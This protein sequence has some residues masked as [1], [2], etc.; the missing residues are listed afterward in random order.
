MGRGKNSKKKK[1]AAAAPDM[2]KNSAKKKPVNGDEGGPV[3][4]EATAS[5]DGITLPVPTPVEPASGDEQPPADGD[6]TIPPAQTSVQPSNGDG[7]SLEA[8]NA[9]ELPVGSAAAAAS[10]DGAP[11]APPTAEAASNGGEMPLGSA[12]AAPDEDGVLPPPPFSVEAPNGDKTPADSAAED[13]GDV[14]SPT[15]GSAAVASGDVLE[16]P[17]SVEEA[18]NGGEPMEER[19]LDEEAPKERRDPSGAEPEGEAENLKALN[20]V[21]VKEAVETRGQVA[22]LTAQVDQ[23]SAD[24]DALA[25]VERDVLKAG[26]IVPFVAAAE[27]CTALRGHVA[28]VQESL[29][30]A[31]ARAAREAD[32]R[33]E[34]AARLKAAEAENLR[35]VELLSGKDAEVASASKNVAG[36]EA[37]VSELA[38]N[39]TKLCSEKCELEKQLG[40]MS[41]SARSVHAQKAEVEA[42]FRDYKMNTEKYKQEIQEKLDEKSRQLEALRSSKAEMEVKLQSLEAD[43]SAALAKNWELESEMHSSKT[44]L[45]AAKTELEKLRFEV[46]DVGKKY[47]AVLAEGDN[48]RNEIE[49]MIVINEG[50]VSAFATEKTK[51]DKEL[52][53]LKRKVDSIRAN[54]DVAMS[55]AHQK[56]AEAAKLRAEMNGLCDSIAEQRVL[57][58]DLRAKSSG[59][60]VEVDTVQKALDLEKAEGGKLRLK[61]GKLES[62]NDEKEHEIGVLKSEV[63]NKRGQIYTLNGELKKLQLAVDVAKQSGKSSVWTWLCP[64]TTVIAAVSFAYAARSR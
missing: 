33:E 4:S 37:V 61:L 10:L 11:P 28:D 36:L 34:A 50:A 31:K 1:A 48:L 46:A 15:V 9:D 24:A 60:Q 7:P 38:G 52:D 12:A 5:G 40:E 6:G 58:D 44:E 30:A 35:F 26:L 51:M 62:Y 13:T 54:K 22:A 2:A 64:T 43:L 32:A 3:D 55:S 19:G 59:L 53:G 17:R 18:D 63:Q 16:Q 47:T 56:D 27:Y 42:S 20:G 14:I 25:G 45:A 39:S 49:K 41:A 21:L 29:Q 23:L 57:C 8:A